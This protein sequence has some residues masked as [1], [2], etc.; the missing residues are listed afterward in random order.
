M[1]VDYGLGFCELAYLPF[2]C[3]P[4]CT[5]AAIPHRRPGR[6]FLCV[7]LFHLKKQTA[8][9]GGARGERRGI[10][11]PNSMHCVSQASAQNPIS[12]FRAL[13]MTRRSG[14][15]A[16]REPSSR[17]VP[18]THREAKWALQGSLAT[19][20]STELLSGSSAF[21]DKQAEQGKCELYT[22]SLRL[23]CLPG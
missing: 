21:S 23:M 3:I 2:S 5:L 18:A 20:C 13:A 10:A 22:W 17:G 16:G 19:S 6:P 12:C 4:A 14:C 15:Q 8:R 1:H 7:P 9:G 11:K